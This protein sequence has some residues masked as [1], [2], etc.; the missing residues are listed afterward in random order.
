MG[1]GTIY[2][3]AKNPLHFGHTRHT[4]TIQ[5]KNSLHVRHTRHIA[6]YYTNER[7]QYEL[8]VLR[9]WFTHVQYTFHNKRTLE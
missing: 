7:G 2:E 8:Q 6:T 9:N 3:T 4:H 5:S 1:H